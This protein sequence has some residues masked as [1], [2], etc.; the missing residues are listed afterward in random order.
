MIISEFH[1]IIL[2]YYKGRAV[3]IDTLPFEAYTDGPW[4]A[5]GQFCRHFFAP[6]ALMA[7]LDE[8]AGKMMQTYIDGI[9]LDLAD[10]L[11]RG[12]G[13]TYTCTPARCGASAARERARKASEK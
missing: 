11:L 2:N 5:Y 12:S 10:N 4:A 1:K 8:R 13:S 6:L 3:L 9:P 7:H